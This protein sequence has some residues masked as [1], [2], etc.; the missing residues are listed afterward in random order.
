MLDARVPREIRPMSVALNGLFRRLSDAR[1]HERDFTA[2]AAHELKTSLA[3]L[4]TQAHIAAMAPD[5]ATRRTALARL[6]TGVNRADLMV[7]VA[8][9]VA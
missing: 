8:E 4:K 6:E 2:F 9:H 3:G 5:D 7:A 1:A